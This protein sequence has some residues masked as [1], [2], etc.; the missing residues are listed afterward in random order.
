[1]SKVAKGEKSAYAKMMDEK[2]RKE[3]LK[4]KGTKTKHSAKMNG[5]CGAKTRTGTFC[6][7]P[8][9]HGTDHPGIGHCRMHGGNMVNHKLNAAKQEAVF[10]GAP[11]DINPVDAL[12]YCI[13]IVAGEVEWLSDQLETV[14]RKDWYEYTLQGKQ[15][16]VL[17]RARGEAMDRLVNYSKIAISLGIAERA[18]RIAEQY[19]ASIARL[20][21]GVLDDLDLTP[22]Q[23]QRAPEIIRKHLILLER[24]AFAAPETIQQDRQRMPEIPQRVSAA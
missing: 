12:M 23:A 8:A 16:H 21:R 1:M 14:N 17:Q 4:K 5:K 20:L 15:L 19:G 10:M 2:R 18:V 22:V 24:G 6:G 13:R 3:R 7:Q 11:R 9:G